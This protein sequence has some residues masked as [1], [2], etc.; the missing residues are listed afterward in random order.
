MM[1]SRALVVITA[2]LAAGGGVASAQE[3]DPTQTVTI[4]VEAAR[5][6]TLEDDTV[7][8]AA[9]RPTETADY[10][11][12]TISYTTDNPGEDYLLASA[13][14]NP[15]NP[16]ED[17]EIALSATGITCDCGS[18][19]VRV[20]GDFLASNVQ[21]VSL[22]DV[23]TAFVTGIYDTGGD[24]ATATLTYTVTTTGALPGEY[25]Y[26]VTFVITGA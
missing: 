2:L 8:G 4:Q 23:A 10:E 20:D 25:Q 11:A 19:G 24:V 22:G 6:I 7:T 14:A 1:R 3:S 18:P 17:V 26:T 13:A 9:L 12:G 21:P 5:T 15:A 16:S